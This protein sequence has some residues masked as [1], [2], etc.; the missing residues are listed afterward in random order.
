MY[1]LSFLNSINDLSVDIDVKN[2][3]EKTSLFKSLCQ[4]ILVF[5]SKTDK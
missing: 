3:S 5:A 1:F 2:A 4:G